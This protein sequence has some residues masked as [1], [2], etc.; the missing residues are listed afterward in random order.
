MAMHVLALGA[1]AYARPG[2]TTRAGLAHSARVRMAA[3]VEADVLV[4]GAGPAG[5]MLVRTARA[6]AR[7]ARRAPTR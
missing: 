4:I 7:R 3:E 5:T 1:L 6:R 2:L